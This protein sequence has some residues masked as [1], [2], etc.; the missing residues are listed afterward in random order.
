MSGFLLKVSDLFVRSINAILTSIIIMKKPSKARVYAALKSLIVVCI[1]L[2]F[3]EFM[4]LEMAISVSADALLY[5]ECFFGIWISG[6]LLRVSPSTSYSIFN[7]VSKVTGVSLPQV[8]S[9]PV[10]ADSGDQ[11]S[12]EDTSDRSRISNQ[13]PL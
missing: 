1:A 4:S 5:L 8:S 10:V 6:I 13:S 2:A 7:F 11:Q 3:L 9:R 12:N